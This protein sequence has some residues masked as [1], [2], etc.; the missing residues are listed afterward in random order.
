[1]GSGRGRPG[2]G[3]SGS[4]VRALGSSLHA[5]SGWGWP[6]RPALRARPGP[7]TLAASSCGFASPALPTRGAGGAGVRG[8]RTPEGT[9]GV[10]HTQGAPGS[11]GDRDGGRGP[12]GPVLHLA[13]ASGSLQTQRGAVASLAAS[14][15][16]QA[17]ARAQ[18]LSAS[19]SGLFSVR[20]EVATDHWCHMLKARI[21]QTGLCPLCDLHRVSGCEVPLPIL[22][23]YLRQSDCF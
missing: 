14:R 22:R 15:K 8:G 7:W 6:G 18:G 9:A 3:E 21:Q 2:S 13:G 19:F 20:E 5:G 16:G 4:C 17:L 1:M 23:Q 10:S 12:G 11:W